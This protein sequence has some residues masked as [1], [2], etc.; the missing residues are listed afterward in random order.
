MRSETLRH[1]HLRLLDNAQEITNK[2]GK[3]SDSV[4]HALVMIQKRRD[5]ILKVED[6]LCSCEAPTVIP[7]P[8][9][10]VQLPVDAKSSA[11]AGVTLVRERAMVDRGGRGGMLERVG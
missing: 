1:G 4:Y 9:T 5:S 8:N 6:G 10:L 3:A 7:R 2:R 11:C